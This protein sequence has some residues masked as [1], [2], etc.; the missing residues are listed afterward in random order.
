MTI[1]SKETAETLELK[2]KYAF[3]Y[4]VNLQAR[5]IQL[6]GE[7]DG[8][9]FELIDSALTELDTINHKQITLRINSEGGSVGDALAIVG[10]INSCKS[11]IITEG[12]G[13]I[14]SAATIILAAG[15]KRRISKHSWFMHHE[16]A[17]DLSGRHSEVKDMVKQR[18]RE[19]NQWAEIMAGLTN[20][21]KG[22]WRKH[23]IYKD[24]YFT[25]EELLKLGVVDEVF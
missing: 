18:D 13:S 9:K 5:T 25:A 17:Y 1:V 8:S 21:D 23:G 16:S 2:L 22:F 3:E 14:M 24:S 15:F 7:I 6:V 4:G 10:R 12:Y 20:K 19:E 11:R